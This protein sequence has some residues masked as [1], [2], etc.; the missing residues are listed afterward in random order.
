MAQMCFVFLITKRLGD[1][2]CF[3]LLSFSH[4][5]TYIKCHTKMYMSYRNLWD[6]CDV[7]LLHTLY[8]AKFV[9][10]LSVKVNTCIPSNNCLF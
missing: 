4:S 7:P 6:T 9:K 8:S 10:V 5:V 3:F 1:H 2:S